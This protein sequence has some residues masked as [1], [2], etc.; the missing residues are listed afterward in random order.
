MEH[1]YA[2]VWYRPHELRL[3]LKTEVLLENLWFVHSCNVGEMSVNY[4]HI[5]AIYEA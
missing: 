3:N 2:F 1:V 4:S 5:V